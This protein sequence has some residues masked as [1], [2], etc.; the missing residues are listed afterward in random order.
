MHQ[1]SNASGLTF[2]QS[3]PAGRRQLEPGHGSGYQAAPA[4][5]PR[6]HPPRGRLDARDTSEGLKDS[7][8][9][10]ITPGPSLEVNVTGVNLV[11]AED[12]GL[13]LNDGCDG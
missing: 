5:T 4:D 8:I 10:D 13:I 1:P 6:C 3:H 11:L 9:P 2:S 7:S 12:P